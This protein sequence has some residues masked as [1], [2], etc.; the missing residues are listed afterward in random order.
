MPK[1]LKQLFALLAEAMTTVAEAEES[2]DQQSDK[3]RDAWREL[4]KARKSP[5]YESVDSWAVEIYEDKVIVKMGD[6]HWSVPYSKADDEVTFDL[7]ASTKVQRQWVEIVSA[8]AEGVSFIRP[9]AEAEG[10]EPSGTEWDVVVITAGESPSHGRIYPRQALAEAVKAGVFEGVRVMLRSDEDHLAGK[11]KSIA[12]V[13]GWIDGVKMKGNEVRGRL[14]LSEAADKL[15]ALLVDAWQ[16][17]KK[18]LAGLSIVGSASGFKSVVRKGRRWSVVEGIKTVSSVDVV[19]DPAMGGGLLD[20]VAAEGKEE[21]VG[22]EALLKAL[23]RAEPDIVRHLLAE[24]TDEELAEIKEAADDGLTTKIEE[25][26]AEPKPDEDK[27]K[28]KP[29]KDDPKPVVESENDDDDEEDLVPRSL[30]RTVVRS[31]LAETK[32]PEIAKKKLERRFAGAAFK[33]DDLTEAISEEIETWAEL[34]K[35]GLVRSQGSSRTGVEVGT[36]EH[37]RAKAALDGFFLEEAVEVDG[38]KIPPYRSFKR[39]YIELTGDGAGDGVITGEI[40]MNG[41]GKLGLSEA[42]GGRTRF[43]KL[44][45]GEPVG[46][47]LVEAIATGGFTEI[48]GDSIRRRMVAEYRRSD[49]RTW[50]SLVDVVPTADFRTNRITRLGG[51]LNLATV[52][53]G[54][55]YAAMTSPT[56]EEATWAVTKRGGTETINLEA[57]ANDDVGFIRRIPTRMARAAAQTLHE[58]V[59]EFLN[60]NAAIYDAV[61]L[62]AAGHNNI[63]S[64]ALSVT[65][66]NAARQRMRKQLEKDNSKRLGFVPAYLIVPIELEETAFVLTMSDKRSGTADNDAS[67]AKAQGLTYTVVD[68]WTDANNWYVA[69]DKAACPLL[70]V[71]FYGPEDPEIFVQD[72]PNVGSMFTNDQ[73]TYKIRHIYGGAVLDFRGLDGSIVA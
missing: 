30:A 12:N 38:E 45:L 37:E 53:Q 54:G 24:A 5:E 47:D 10:E 23:R 20:L 1:K 61:A 41:G 33:E 14:H 19:Y 26:L 65:S 16:R 27:D 46:D 21:S 66:L 40:P 44:H 62:F 72:L 7:E 32:L 51:Y 71:G 13:V 39:A 70:E 60:S 42:N 28:G 59:Y 4:A 56:D 6:D 63:G 34:E 50:E 22:L 9:V 3:V 49:L 52:A 15:R 2:L 64:T 48:L 73:A 57:I 67:F 8:V 55:A 58:F 36:E 11:G 69:A 31:A 43:K 17:G 18:D 29:K 25:A 68:Y 35:S